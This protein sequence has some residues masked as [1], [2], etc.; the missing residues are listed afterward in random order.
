M[1]RDG[2]SPDEAQKRIDS[3]MPQS[4]KQKFADYL[5]D[6]SDGFELTRQRTTEVYDQLTRVARQHR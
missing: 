2:L 4:E 6:T 3:Q 1:L 5:I